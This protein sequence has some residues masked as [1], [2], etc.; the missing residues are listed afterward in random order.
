[1]TEYEVTNNETLHQYEARVD[2]S[3][4]LAQ[5]K[6][7]GNEIIFFHTETPVVLRGRGVASA[8][9]QFALEDARDK[10][11]TVVPS[12]WFVSDFIT[13]HPEFLPLVNPEDRARLENASRS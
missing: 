13:G 12:C 1:M 2:G 8:V 6:R 5:Y 9:V 7:H 10:G 11:L 4:A 3:L